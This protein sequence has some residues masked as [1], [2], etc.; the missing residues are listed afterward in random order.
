MIIPVDTSDN[1][2]P[3]IRNNGVETDAGN[4]IPNGKIKLTI[5]QTK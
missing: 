3:I 2:S 1:K 5:S 4:P